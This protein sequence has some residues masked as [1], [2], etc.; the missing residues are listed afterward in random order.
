MRIT[1]DPGARADLDYIFA[2]ISRDNAAAC[3]CDDLAHRD[4]I[5]L[6]ATPGLE[7]VGRPGL[8]E[9]TRELIEYPYIVVYE[10]FE[11]REE[12]VVWSIFHGAQS[13]EREGSWSNARNASI[14]VPL[15]GRPPK[16][17]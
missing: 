17:L 15:R 16:N 11:T 6:L 14:R 5:A 4:K 10:V 12:I 2:W 9:G 13:R 7:H 1:F 3:V 8:D